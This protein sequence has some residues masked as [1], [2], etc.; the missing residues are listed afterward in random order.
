VDILL[1][2]FSQAR[3]W[4]QGQPGRQQWCLQERVVGTVAGQCCPVKVG[5]QGQGQY[6]QPLRCLHGKAV[7]TAAGQCCPV[8]VGWQGQ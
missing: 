8:K 2:Q 7:G 3:M 6:R 1:V 4:W 5:W